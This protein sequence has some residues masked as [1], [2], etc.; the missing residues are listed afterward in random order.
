M[1]CA[2]GGL[3]KALSEGVALHGIINLLTPEFGI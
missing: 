3:E 1:V 2:Y